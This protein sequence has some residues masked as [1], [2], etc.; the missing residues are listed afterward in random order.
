MK[1]RLLAIWG[2]F[3][4]LAAAVAWFEF[5]GSHSED[6][7]HGHG[8]L[9]QGMLVPLPVEQLGAVEVVHGGALHRFDRDPAGQWYY[10]GVHQAATDPAHGHVTD[11]EAAKRIEAAFVALG[12]AKLEREFAISDAGAQYG[13]ASPQMVLLLLARGQTQPVIQYAV[14]DVAADTVS[15]YVMVVGG[16]QAATIPDYQIANLLQLI[17]SFAQAPAPVPGIPGAAPAAQAPAAASRQ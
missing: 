14:G 3:A 7:A 6:D 15:R 2:V 11:P 8:K 1:P 17:G 16:R 4:V 10:H 12:R 9:Q 5:G 13:L